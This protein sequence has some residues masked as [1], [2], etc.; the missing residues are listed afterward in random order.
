L[1]RLE[2]VSLKSPNS[3]TL[4]SYISDSTASV[5][6]IIIENCNAITLHY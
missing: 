6:S 1:V 4:A 2:V 5:Q 3:Q